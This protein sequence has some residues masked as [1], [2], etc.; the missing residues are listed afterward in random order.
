MKAQVY[1]ING[2]ESKKIDLPSFFSEQVREDILSKVLEAKKTKQPY[3]ASP[4]AGKQ[5]SASGKLIHK[6]KVWKS[7]YGR[8]MSRIPRK[9]MWVRGS[10]F[11]WEGAFVPNTRGGRRAHPP[12]PYSMINTKKINKKESKKAFVSALIASITPKFIAKKYERLEEKDIKA[13][14]IVESKITELK[15]KDLLK[16][17]KSIFG[18]KLFEVAVKNK[19]IRAGI[20]KL[21]GRRYKKS[22]GLLIVIGNNENLKTNQ[23]DVQKVSQLGIED[24]A[25]GSPGRLTIYT[26]NAIKDLGKK[27]GGKNE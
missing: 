24:L 21:R 27:V 2:K 17:L 15:T 16:S 20:G 7:Q 19:K 22:P 8:G 4:V 10:Q 9:T 18:D 25:K 13:P 11:N 26:E 23:F 1:D 6:R 12:R 14:I 3:G 5:Y